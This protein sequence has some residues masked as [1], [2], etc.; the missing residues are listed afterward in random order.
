VSQPATSSVD[1][2]SPAPALAG[3]GSL[4]VLILVL[5]CAG[6]SPPDMTTYSMHVDSVRIDPRTDT[7]VLLL[8]ETDGEKRQ[9]PI[10]IGPYEARSIAMEM[11]KITSPRPNTHDL[12]VNILAGI[13]GNLERVVITDLRD[14]TY[15]AVIEIDVNGH[16]VSVD[17]RPSDAIAVAVRT[18]TPVFAAAAL[19]ERLDLEGSDSPP[20][21]ILW[22]PDGGSVSDETRSY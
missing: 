15:Y 21:Q 19:L 16:T 18:G 5:A 17:S 8:E 14:N 1:L 4:L 3:A 2:R 7:P 10:W 12:I 22:R 6:S 13:Q 20:M 9:L 11:E